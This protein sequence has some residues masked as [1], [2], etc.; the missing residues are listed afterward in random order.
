MKVL[1]VPSSGKRAQIVSY[2]GR[3]GQVERAYVIPRNTQTPARRHMR[4]WFGYWS[5]VWHTVLTEAQR[6]AWIA[7]AA[8]VETR[9]RCGQSGKR[10][11]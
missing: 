5:R 1:T 10:T 3:Y 7:A 8:S 9:P 4:Y 11:G 6:R 2:R